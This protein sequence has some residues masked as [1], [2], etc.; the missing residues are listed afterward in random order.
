MAVEPTP[1]QIHALPLR[2]VE[3]G[4]EPYA[5]L[6]ILTPHGR[7]MAKHLRHRGWLPQSDGSYMPIELPG[8]ANLEVWEACFGVYEVIL[9][10]LRTSPENSM[11]VTPIALETYFQ[12]FRQLARDHSESWHL[13][14]QAE[15]RCRAEHMPRIRRRIHDETGT[16]P[17]WSQVFIAAAMDDR[18]W[19]AEVRRPALVF[20]ARGH[21]RPL[22][23]EPAP[24]RLTESGNPGSGGKDK[25]KGRGKGKGK[26]ALKKPLLKN[27]DGLYTTDKA[28]REICFA[29]ASTD[30]CQTPCPQGRSH[31]CQHCLGS[32]PN[33][34]CRPKQ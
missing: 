18:Y 1:D 30:S 33:S 6:S 11:V 15:D 5:D 14:Q 13:C 20:L 4:A 21:K 9:L 19:D 29:F 22:S 17:T 16:Q 7:R 31:V 2:V 24:E 23:D 34:G 27:K 8:P 25:G 26:G 32:H 28:G 12:H 3:L 10:M